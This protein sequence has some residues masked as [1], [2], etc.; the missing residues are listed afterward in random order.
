M[1]VL[2]QP[3]MIY[4]SDLT[5]AGSYT[6]RHIWQVV[7]CANKRTQVRGQTAQFIITPQK[8]EHVRKTSI[9]WRKKTNFYL[10]SETIY[11]K[12]LEECGR[13]IARETMAYLEIKSECGLGYIFLNTGTVSK[14]DH[15]YVGHERLAE[16]GLN[17]A[18]ATVTARQNSPP[19]PPQ[20]LHI[21]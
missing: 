6:Y 8:G 17:L 4:T 15:N 11:S 10:K 13:K 20:C 5:T 14:P 1:H 21:S 3:A 7:L 2:P 9:W 16:R 12:I 18:G 19:S